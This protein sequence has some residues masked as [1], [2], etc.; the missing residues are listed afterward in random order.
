[1]QQV[2]GEGPWCCALGSAEP[3]ESG[4]S[5]HGR[6]PTAALAIAGAKRAGSARSRPA[7]LATQRGC[8]GSFQGSDTCRAQ[9]QGHR[10]L[11][12][13]CCQVLLCGCVPTAQSLLPHARGAGPSDIRLHTF[14]RGWKKH[15]CHSAAPAT[16]PLPFEARVHAAVWVPPGLQSR[17]PHDAHTAS[18]PMVREASLALL[19][20][21]C[22]SFDKRT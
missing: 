3:N 10:A 1:M 4:A 9:Y 5:H 2:S 19:A 17:L 7:R 18:V 13:R 14:S 11:D 21:P 20:L 8:E 22:A 12:S 15:G 6:A 16:G